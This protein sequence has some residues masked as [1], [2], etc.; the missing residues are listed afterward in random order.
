MSAVA[1]GVPQAFTTAHVDAALRHLGDTAA[2]PGLDAMAAAIAADE[3]RKRMTNLAPTGVL[4]A[5]S[6]A[7]S[8]YGESVSKLPIGLS[9]SGSGAPDQTASEPTAWVE[10]SRPPFQTAAFGETTGSR[11]GTLRSGNGAYGSG[12]AD[13]VLQQQQGAGT[14]GPNQ[15]DRHA[16]YLILRPETALQELNRDK[17]ELTVDGRN[18]TTTVLYGNPKPIV[19]GGT[20]TGY[21]VTD[22]RILSADA[23]TAANPNLIIVTNEDAAYI[24]A[25]TGAVSRIRR[26]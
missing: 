13:T 21:I 3:F 9:G 15:G 1:C 12:L 26:T 6:R 17:V 16:E 10:A 25:R 20:V 18:Y 4:A 8:G 24:N 23:G 22:A 2:G 11:G 14:N 5:D 7:L 19:E